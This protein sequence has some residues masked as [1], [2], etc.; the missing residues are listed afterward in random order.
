MSVQT[1]A[2][3]ILLSVTPMASSAAEPARWKT[4]ERC[5]PADAAAP[6]KG[7]FE[8]R[9]KTRGVDAE[10]IEIRGCGTNRTYRKVI[11]WGGDAG[12]IEAY[13][14]PFFDK[15]RRDLLIM[16][17]LDTDSTYYLLTA[18][19]NYEKVAIQFSAID[20]PYF[21]DSDGDGRWE[22]RIQNVQSMSCQID[23]KK[24]EN[25]TIKHGRADLSAD[26]L[27]KAPADDGHP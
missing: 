10:A 13:A 21:G 15:R 27:C 3:I 6:G 20:A 16:H 14:I 5:L 9:Y 26:T 11:K 19:S 23:N 18:A 17:G 22:I 4:A 25:D 8:V 1:T 7:H 12:V 24:W 2:A